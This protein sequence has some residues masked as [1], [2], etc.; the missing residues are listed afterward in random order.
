MVIAARKNEKLGAAKEQLAKL[1]TEPNPR[2]RIRNSSGTFEVTLISMDE[3]R[4]TV[5]VLWDGNVHREFKW[6]SILWGNEGKEVVAKAK[7]KPG[8]TT[9]GEPKTQ[10]PKSIAKKKTKTTPNQSTPAFTSTTTA[11]GNGF[12]PPPPA[13]YQPGANGTYPTSYAV[14]PGYGYGYPYPYYYP[15]YVPPG[16]KS[17]PGTQTAAPL[18]YPAY[19]LPATQQFGFRSAPT[20][21]QANTASNST[22]TTITAPVSTRTVTSVK[23]PTTS[24]TS[25]TSNGHQKTDTSEGLK[26]LSQTA[27]TAQ[28][29]GS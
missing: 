18:P 15:T 22:S 8:P 5:V 17:K 9:N 19:S 2:I 27:I 14:Q 11:T 4:N 6:G 1:L 20:A 23:T 21:A 28:P 25:M 24:A 7:E 13:F 16:G 10:Q 3:Q 29:S 12:Y 26:A